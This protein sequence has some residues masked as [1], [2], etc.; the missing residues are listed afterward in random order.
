MGKFT[1]L[2]FEPLIG[3]VGDI[4][5]NPTTDLEGCNE[6]TWGVDSESPQL[7]FV[8]SEER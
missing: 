5:L 8:F 1:L 6:K 2:T 7:F 3:R 4:E